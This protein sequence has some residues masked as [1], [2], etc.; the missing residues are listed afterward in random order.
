[1]SS[2]SRYFCLLVFCPQYINGCKTRHC[3]VI[4]SRYVLLQRNKDIC[5]D[6]Y[7]T[8]MMHIQLGAWKCTRS[9]SWLS[10]PN[11]VCSN[12]NIYQS[13]CFYFPCRNSGNCRI[14]ENSFLIKKEEQFFKYINL[15]RA[16][17]GRATWIW[18]LWW[19]WWGVITGRK[20]L[21]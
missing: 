12:I 6:P 13:H 4:F 11:S 20:N 2:T 16:M 1:M 21:H 17:S 7:P 3:K 15:P 8:I 10:S 14:A 5:N 18:G 9:L 19:W